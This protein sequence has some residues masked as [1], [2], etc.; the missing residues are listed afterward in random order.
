M[1]SIADQIA[2]PP[3]ADTVLAKD[4]AAAAAAP[5]ITLPVAKG[6]RGLPLGI[7]FVA[8]YRQDVR[9]LRVAKWA[10]GVLAYDA[11]LPKI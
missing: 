5:A 4:E 10:E 9:L 6:P 2:G 3:V 8:P 7:Q 11:G 1:T